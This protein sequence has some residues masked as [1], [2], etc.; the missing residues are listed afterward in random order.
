M[1]HQEPIILHWNLHKGYSESDNIRNE[2]LLCIIKRKTLNY[3][4]T[5]HIYNIDRIWSRAQTVCYMHDR[6]IYTHVT[7]SN[8]S[9]SSQGPGPFY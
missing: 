8:S 4:R 5:N 1:L 9:R 6:Q 7:F 2:Y 3:E